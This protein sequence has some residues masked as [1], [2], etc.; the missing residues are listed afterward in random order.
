MAANFQATLLDVTDSI[1]P[2][3]WATPCGGPS[4]AMARGSIFA[5]A[6]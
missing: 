2:G 1:G 6:G 5:R 3:G 4:S